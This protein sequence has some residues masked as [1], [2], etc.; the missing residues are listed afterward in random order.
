MTRRVVIIG[1][2]GSGKSYLAR[3]LGALSQVAVVHL[4]AIFWVPGGFSEKRPAEIVE[5]EIEERKKGA[6]WI[7][8]GVFGELAA[9]FLDRADL[10]IWLDMP[11]PVCEAG[12]RE[13]GSESAQQLDPDKAEESFRQ[14]ILWAADYRKRTGPRSHA[15]HARLFSEFAGEKIRFDRRIEVDLYLLQIHSRRNLD[16]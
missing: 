10:L 9:R 11:W 12:L 3:K 7:V 5:R 4:D 14:L 1:N 8:E 2:S 6:A 15:G 16:A 13:R